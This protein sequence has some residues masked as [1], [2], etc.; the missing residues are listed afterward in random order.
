MIPKRIIDAML[1]LLQTALWDKPI[2]ESKFPLDEMEW[3]QLYAMARRQAVNTILFDAL[4]F[5]HED[6]KPP[7]ELLARW[8]VDTRNTEEGFAWMHKVMTAQNT[9]WTDRDIHA[10]LMKGENIANMYP[11]PEHR[12]C[13]DI[14][15]YFP[16][17]EDWSY[18]NCMAIKAGSTPEVDSDG[19]TNYIWKGVVVEHHK[20]WVRL[21]SRKGLKYI[22]SLEE[23]FDYM[24]EVEILPPELNVFLINAHILKHALVLGVG[25]RQICDLAMAYKFYYGRLDKNL[26]CKIVRR[27]GLT[28]WTELLHSVL[29]GPIGMP[30]KYLPC[31]PNERDITKMMELV[32]RDG[33]FGS[34][35][36]GKIGSLL[37]RFPMFMRY[38]PR[39]YF[40]RICSLAIGR[41]NR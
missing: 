5:L 4:N 18:A 6:Q 26:Y 9:T 41:I 14:D 20:Q 21:S 24:D 19:D 12:S 33:N 11:H 8:L 10:V 23:K 30:E 31:E 27:C 17:P 36:V 29:T 3:R 15:W 22:K 39:E 2:D 34:R 32:L 13:G 1:A 25:L 38:A 28:R 35:R 40:T 7:R 16:T 37:K